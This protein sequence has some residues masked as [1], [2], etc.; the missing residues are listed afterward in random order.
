M[1]RKKRG[2]LCNVGDFVTIQTLYIILLHEGLNI[3]FDVGN[4]GREAG[5]DLLDHLLDELDVSH[6][7]SR[8]HDANDSR[9]LKWLDKWS[10]NV[11]R[12]EIV[13]TYLKQQ[14]T[15]LLYRL[16]RVV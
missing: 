10:R 14:L 6:L 3:L 11:N 16:V 2:R 15:V 13:K 7:L 9:L 12:K 8:L 5:F 4:L 1:Y